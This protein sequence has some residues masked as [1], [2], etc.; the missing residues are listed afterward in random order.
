VRILIVAEAD[1]ESEAS[2]AERVLAGQCAGLAARGHHVTV[3]AGVKGGAAPAGAGREIEER[4]DGVRVARYR[5]GL[6][7]L[8]EPAR[9]FRRLAPPG[10]FDAILFHQPFSALGLLLG[11][12]GRSLPAGYVFLSPWHEEFGIRHP[13]APSLSLRFRRAL[14]GMVIRRCRRVFPMSR[15]MAGRLRAIHGIPPERISVVPGGVDT[16]RFKPASDRARVRL[17]L[18][19]PPSA[20]IFFTLRNLEP[21]MG[22]DRLLRAVPLVAQAV[23]DFTLVVGGQGP[24]LSSLRALASELGLGERVRFT[25]FIPEE[26]LVSYY[27]AADGFVIPTVELEGFGL[28]ILEALACG[29]P[30]VGSRVGAIPELLEPLDPSLLIH[31]PTPEGIAEGILALVSRSDRDSLSAAC[32]EHVLRSYR[33]EQ[34]IE[35]LERGLKEIAE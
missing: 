8:L 22:V 23:P 29:T 32:R 20:T 33:W 7:A 35:E 21:R 24:L 18:G 26:A 10:G 12:R 34:V 3:V 25:G 15:F 6:T 19:L 17:S 27:Q 1:P 30:V 28:P 11:P 13:A 9:L 16:G 4:R 5:L 2:G 14:E 31:S